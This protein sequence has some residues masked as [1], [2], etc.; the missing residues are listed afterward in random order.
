MGSQ[1]E[2]VGARTRGVVV[3]RRGAAA[4]GHRRYACRIRWRFVPELRCLLTLTR[5]QAQEEQEAVPEHLRRNQGFDLRGKDYSGGTWVFGLFRVW[6]RHEGARFMGATELWREIL[7]DPVPSA[8]V[9]PLRGL[10]A[11]R[12]GGD[13]LAGGTTQRSGSRG[14]VRRHGSSRSGI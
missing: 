4:G 2:R 13:G 14:A 3:S 7:D 5:R 8:A 12:L 1:E 9:P 10:T 11:A 6:L